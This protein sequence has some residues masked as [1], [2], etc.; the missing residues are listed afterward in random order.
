MDPQALV[1]RDRDGRPVRITRL[2]QATWWWRAYFSRGAPLP[3]QGMFGRAFTHFRLVY[4]D[5][6]IVLD[7]TPFR[8]PALMIWEYSGGR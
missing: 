4:A 6:Q 8:G 1:V 3:Q 2:A 5:P 7:R